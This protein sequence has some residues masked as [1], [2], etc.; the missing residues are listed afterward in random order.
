LSNI[1]H[2]YTIFTCE[3]NFSNLVFVFETTPTN[4]NF[5]S[6]LK[7]NLP[8]W[9]ISKMGSSTLVFA[10]LALFAVRVPQILEVV[11]FRARITVYFLG[12]LLLYSWDQPPQVVRASN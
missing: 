9:K 11:L 10:D 7:G 1:G 12:G 6:K 3:K 4:K 2:R 5:T 8:K